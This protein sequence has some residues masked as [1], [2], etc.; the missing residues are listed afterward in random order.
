MPGRGEGMTDGPCWGL[1]GEGGIHSAFGR[2][3]GL[4][5]SQLAFKGC[6]GGGQVKY[7]QKLI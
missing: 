5:A 3:G 4:M 7:P 6:R 2:V 1:R